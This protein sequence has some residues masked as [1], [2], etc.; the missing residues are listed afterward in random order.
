MKK[1]EDFR[2]RWFFVDAKV[3]NHLLDMPVAPPKKW[4]R[5]VSEGFEG[6]K[7]DAVYECLRGLRD[8]GLTGQ[9][10]AKDFTQRRIADRKSVV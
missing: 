8:T 7:L 3:K 10:V 9:M 4:A 1:V 5:W 6:P 2:Q